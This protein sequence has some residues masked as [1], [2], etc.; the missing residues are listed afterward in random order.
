VAW[1]S[2]GQW[3]VGRGGYSE[4]STHTS[5]SIKHAISRTRIR[6]WDPYQYGYEKRGFRVRPTVSEQTRTVLCSF[7]RWTHISTNTLPVLHTT[8]RPA[9]KMT[10]PFHSSRQRSWHINP[11]HTQRRL[12]SPASNSTTWCRIIWHYL[13]TERCSISWRT[14]RSFASLIRVL[15]APTN[16]YKYIFLHQSSSTFFFA[17]TV[18]FPFSRM[19][20]G[21]DVPRL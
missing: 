12:T 14:V 1:G 6:I 7:E 19:L 5:D 21:L 17:T 4:R 11:L 15:K 2:R 10:A 8:C 13:R 20:A 18:V 16:I 9:E 3:G